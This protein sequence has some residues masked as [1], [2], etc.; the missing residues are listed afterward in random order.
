MVLKFQGMQ[1][2]FSTPPSFLEQSGLVPCPDSPLRRYSPDWADSSC[3]L[4]PC[5]YLHQKSRSQGFPRLLPS[6]PNQ[7]NPMTMVQRVCSGD[8]SFIT[9]LTL[10][11]PGAFDSHLKP[12]IQTKVYH[13][14]RHLL[15]S[16]M[17]TLASSLQFAPNIGANE[18]SY[19]LFRTRKQEVFSAKTPVCLSKE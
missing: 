8:S 12:C 13:I 4:A 19:Q 7:N 18:G 2:S 3:S 1:S 16:I 17:L 15:K 11:E 10:P 9:V 6:I 5:G 14:E